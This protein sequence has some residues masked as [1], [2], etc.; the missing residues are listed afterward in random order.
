MQ[1]LRKMALMF[2]MAGV[3]LGAQYSFAQQEIAPDHYDQPIPAKA[4][5]KAPTH[6][7]AAVHHP[8]G[9]STT[10]NHRAKVR[11]PQPAA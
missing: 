4:A 1:F 8:N 7:S 2:V 5:A 9:K 3:S 11:N 10:A 6:K